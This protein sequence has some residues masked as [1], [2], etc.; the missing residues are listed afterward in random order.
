MCETTD[1]IVNVLDQEWLEQSGKHFR[2]YPTTLQLVIAF[3][4]KRKAYDKYKSICSNLEISHDLVNPKGIF[5]NNEIDLKEIQVYGF[6]YDYTLAYY[7]VSLY[8][9]IFNL[10]RDILV[11]HFKYSNEIK[12][13]VY[14]PNFPISGL[15]LDKLKGWLIKINS[16]HNIQ[17]SSVYYG[18][19]QVDN[20]YII[21]FYGGTR[22]NIDDIGYTQSSSTLHYAH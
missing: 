3:S 22:L 21:R 6:D 15:R 19:N 7:N 8:N 12:N 9:F 2:F 4:K 13:L 20:E 1:Q 14:L 11:E 5:C 17:F 16:Y 18:M 10:A